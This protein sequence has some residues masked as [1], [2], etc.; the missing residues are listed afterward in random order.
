[1]VFL[2]WLQL[3][4]IIAAGAIFAGAIVSGIASRR[5]LN[6]LQSVAPR[7]RF[8]LLGALAFF[9]LALGVAAVAIAFAPSVLDAA[10]LVADHCAHHG[11]H[12]FHLCFVHGHPP[13]PSPLILGGGLI[14][15]LWLAAGYSEEFAR[16]RRATSWSETFAQ[17]GRFDAKLGGWT[18]AAERPIAATVGMLRPRICVSDGL[19]DALSAQQLRAVLAHEQA[20]AGRYDALVKFVVRLAA[21][22]H[23]PWVRDRLLEELELACEQACDEAAADVVGDR[24]TVAEAIL[25]V[26]RAMGSVETP[27]AVL[28]FGDHA[29]QR[30]VA[31]MLDA[32]WQCPPWWAIAASGGAALATVVWSY[33]LLHH[34]AES[35]LLHIF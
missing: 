30:R 26:E 4:I 18:I 33:E 6:R 34:A 32:D 8:A 24:L 12:A 19:K 25:A 20:H 5:W 29:L 10:G 23:L 3:V 14:A 11:G 1:M 15:S 31:S 13:A 22:L 16:L 35:L 27:E 21:Q 28:G 2:G 9:P 17:L 7:A